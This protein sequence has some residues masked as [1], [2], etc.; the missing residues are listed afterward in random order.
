M[1]K[2][3][4]TTALT[5]EMQKWWKPHL[6]E[7]GFSQ[8]GRTYNRLNESGFTDVISIQSDYSNPDHSMAEFKRNFD[9]TRKYFTMN[10]GVFVP[11]VQRLWHDYP[12]KK[13]ISEVDCCIRSRI[14]SVGREFEDV[15]WELQKSEQLYSDV[16]QTIKFIA[17]PYFKKYATR[18]N[19][20]TET[21]ERLGI[22]PTRIVQALILFEQGKTQ[23]AAQLLSDQVESS[24]DHPGH[25]E[26]IR[27]LAL[28]LNLS[29]SRR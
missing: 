5:N 24:V 21:S 6:K 7:M 25:Q 4:L 19:I 9:G 26:H 23:E 27:E 12:Q 13:I 22:S 28:K 3:S 17:L 1:A 20:L 15:W 8:S 10:M 29:L 2:A 11:E 14:G 18:E 16:L